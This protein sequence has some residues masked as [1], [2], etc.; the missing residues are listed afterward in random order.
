[1]TDYKPGDI[2]LVN[3]LFSEGG[4]AK[5]RPALVISSEQYQQERQE[6]VMAA[7]T[8]NVERRLI[9]DTIVNEWKKAGLALPSMVTGIIRTIKQAMTARRVGTL[10]AHDYGSVK[11]S[12]GN[13]IDL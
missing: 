12:L 8:S 7:I 1:M 4:G 6:I 9:G 13:V 2:I 5:K 10:T 11:K 3:F